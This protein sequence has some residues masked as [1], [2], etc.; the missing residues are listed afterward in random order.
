MTKH[1]DEILAILKG[2][3]EPKTRREIA[4]MMNI[5]LGR[6]QFDLTEMINEGTISRHTIADID[7]DEHGCPFLYY[8]YSASQGQGGDQL[9]H[10]APTTPRK[11][12]AARRLNKSEMG[13]PIQK[14]RDEILLRRISPH[15]LAA[16][17]LEISHDPSRAV[18]DQ[19]AWSVVTPN[20]VGPTSITKTAVIG[21]ATAL[22]ATSDSP[23]S[24]VAAL[25][26]LLLTD[27]AS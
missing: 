15:E 19:L 14:K 1:K 7:S 6:I 23:R 8:A 5:H 20:A 17:G 16:G 10:L 9:P 27:E 24:L 12:L 11:G 4:D 2:I 25:L 13:T 26:E 21:A 3:R 22:L 18:S